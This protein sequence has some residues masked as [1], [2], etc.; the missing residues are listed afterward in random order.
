MYVY[1]LRRIIYLIPVML[2]VVTVVFFL[3][4]LIPGD[5]AVVMAGANATPEDVAKMRQFMGLDKPL[6]EQYGR[7]VFQVLQGNLGN[8]IVLSRTVV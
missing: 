3:V 4:H 5:P 7:W 6:Y 8:S 1:L 2:V